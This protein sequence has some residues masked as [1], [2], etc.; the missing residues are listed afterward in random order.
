MS[1]SMSHGRKN[2]LTGLAKAKRAHALERNEFRTPSEPR[3]APDGATSAPIKA[4]DPEVRKMID[5]ALARRV[6]I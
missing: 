2:H 4:E 5:E 1:R 3:V 6:Q